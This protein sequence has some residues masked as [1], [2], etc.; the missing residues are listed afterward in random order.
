[1]KSLFKTKAQLFISGM[2]FDEK[3]KGRTLLVT[4]VTVTI[5]KWMMMEA[6][7]FTNDIALGS[8]NIRD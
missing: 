7:H 3:N 5:T 1:M 2:K 4:F 8:E 6:E